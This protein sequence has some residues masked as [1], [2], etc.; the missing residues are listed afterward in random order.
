MMANKRYHPNMTQAKKEPPAPFANVPPKL[1]FP[2]ARAQYVP[3]ANPNPIVAVM[4]TSTNAMLV[5][6]EQMVNMKDRRVMESA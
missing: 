5:R 6:T 1:K 4:K 3:V 2:K